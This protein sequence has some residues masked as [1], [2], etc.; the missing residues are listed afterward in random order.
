LRFAENLQESLRA[1]FFPSKQ[2]A[3]MK[4]SGEPQLKD[5]QV[6]HGN[7]T[8]EQRKWATNPHQAD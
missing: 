1:A 3:R 4:I 8:L 2:R 7:C 6:V 5:R